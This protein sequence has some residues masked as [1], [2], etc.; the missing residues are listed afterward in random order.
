MEYLKIDEEPLERFLSQHDAVSSMLHNQMSEKVKAR[1]FNDFTHLVIRSLRI[2]VVYFEFYRPLPF[3]AGM[4]K[5]TISKASSKFGNRRSCHS[6]PTW[7]DDSGT[8]LV[9]APALGRQGRKTTLAR[10]FTPEV[11]AGDIY[12]I[13]LRLVQSLFTAWA[14]SSFDRELS[15]R[16][17]G[18]TSSTAQMVS[19]YV[20]RHGTAISRSLQLLGSA[21]KPD[22]SV[23]AAVDEGFAAPVYVGVKAVV[24][25]V[26]PVGIPAKLLSA[27]QSQDPFFWEA[28]DQLKP[29]FPE[30]LQRNLDVDSV[31]YQPGCLVIPIIDH[32]IPIAFFA[33]IWHEDRPFPS[34]AHLEI[35]RTWA[36]E[37]SRPSK[38]LF[39]RKFHKMIIE[40]IFSSRNTRIDSG[41][42][43]VLMPFTAEWSER[44]WDRIIRPTLT[45]MGLT[46]VRA[47][48]LFGHDV[49]EDIWEMINTSEFV[50]ADITD[51]NA[52]V[53]YE[54]GIAHTLGKKVILTTQT[55]SD[56]PFDLNRYRH[57]VYRDNVDGA[58]YLRKTLIQK[59]SDLRS[60]SV[61]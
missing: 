2:D 49:M 24:V 57:I 22:L 28:S 36:G 10:M 19:K 52:N 23:F 25:D 9:E 43:C 39:Q 37:I 40:P 14:Q 17:E 11:P 18:L 12:Q 54:L 34:A 45:G 51:R 21:L 35:I 50:I 38:Y 47:D 30:R 3:L 46:A 4:T 29:F 31:K 5:F 27:L 42:C 44:T 26:K 8:K 56:I 16:L 32:S 55:T 48:D 33:C 53:F 13:K 60:K 58:D 41:K 15:H 7:V 61:L 20:D 59:I 6:R 1:Q